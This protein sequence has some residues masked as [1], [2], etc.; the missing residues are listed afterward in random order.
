MVAVLHTIRS[1]RGPDRI[2]HKLGVRPFSA[3]LRAGTALNDDAALFSIPCKP[4]K[5]RQSAREDFCLSHTTGHG[6]KTTPKWGIKPPPTPFFAIFDPWGG[7]MPPGGGCIPRYG[8][9]GLS[10]QRFYTRKGVVLSPQGGGFIPPIGSWGG[11]VITPLGCFY[12][13]FSVI[14]SPHWA[15]GGVV[16]LLGAEGYG[17]SLCSPRNTVP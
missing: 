12:P 1:Q 3:V 4:R 2:K 17:P 5:P 15:G 14:L 11:G 7:F 10:P 13:P 8:G 16:T 6:Y 9:V